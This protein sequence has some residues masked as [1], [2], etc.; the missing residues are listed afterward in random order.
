MNHFPKDSRLG[1]MATLNT[2]IEFVEL[3]ESG[4]RGG[5]ARSDLPA[6]TELIRVPASESI[7][8]S[9][10]RQSEYCRPFSEM[11]DMAVMS[12]YLCHLRKLPQSNPHRAYVDML[13][14]DFD[15]PVLWPQWHDFQGSP[16]VELLQRRRDA[17]REE[18]N[19]IRRIRPD[20]PFELDEYVFNQALVGSRTL[21]VEEPAFELNLVPYIELL[22]HAGAGANAKW[23]F[24]DG[25]FCVQLVQ[26]VQAGQEITLNYGDK[27]NTTLMIDYG[28]QMPDN[29]HNTCELKTLTLYNHTGCD[30]FQRSWTMLREQV[31]KISPAAYSDVEIERSCLQRV[32]I[33]I[34]ICGAE[35]Y[36]TAIEVDRAALRGNLEHRRREAL[37]YLVAEKTLIQ[38]WGVFIDEIETWVASGGT[39]EEVRTAW[40]RDPDVFHCYSRDFWAGCFD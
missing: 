27:S 9:D 15:H 3:P 16:I 8:L 7:R 32:R 19:E 6:G 36:S 34:Q 40:E 10:V 1:G 28:F 4:I 38:E 14:V 24:T 12:I 37:R 13:P 26:P 5:R 39:A 21:L 25:A 30:A 2:D 17:M 11:S 35:R 29:S 22:N 33:E 31:R 18:F 23:N 20:L